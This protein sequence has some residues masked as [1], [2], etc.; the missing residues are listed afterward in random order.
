[1]VQNILRDYVHVLTGGFPNGVFVCGADF[2][3]QFR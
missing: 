2:R 3:V 1:M